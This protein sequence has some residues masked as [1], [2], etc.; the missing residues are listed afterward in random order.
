MQSYDDSPGHF[1]TCVALF[2]GLHVG[3][4]GIAVRRKSSFWLQGNL[5]WSVN[6]QTRCAG[7][8]LMSPGSFL[9]KSQVKGLP[10]QFPKMKASLVAEDSTRI[11]C[12]FV[13]GESEWI[14]KNIC[15]TLVFGMATARHMKPAL[16]SSIVSDSVCQWNPC[17]IEAPFCL[18]LFCCFHKPGI[19]LPPCC[20]G[21]SRLRRLNSLAGGGRTVTCTCILYTAWL[22]KHWA[23]VWGCRPAD[24]TAK[25]MHDG[26]W[27]K[28]VARSSSVLLI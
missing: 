15:A 12:F 9:Q 19:Q 6:V 28:T 2:G 3:S 26:S 25:S 11:F 17:R 7:G 23:S 18:R 21:S 10:T 20:R 16:I 8:F 5:I 22:G 27:L 14:Q 13:G 24:C 1:Q 4:L